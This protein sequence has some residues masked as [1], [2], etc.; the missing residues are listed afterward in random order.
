[1]ISILIRT[2]QDNRIDRNSKAN[3]KLIT[4]SGCMNETAFI[5]TKSGISDE[6][7]S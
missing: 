7:S 3:S 4:L 2:Y 6:S 5:F 1:M